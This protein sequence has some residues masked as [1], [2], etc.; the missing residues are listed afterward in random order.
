MLNIEEITSDDEGDDMDVSGVDTSSF[1]VGV[2]K[3]VTKDA[4]VK[5]TLLV[6]GSGWN[7]VRMDRCAFRI[8][9]CRH[10]SIYGG[11][12]IITINVLI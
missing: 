4:G 9:I 11:N 7:T 6:E 12:F 3:N 10:K 8:E 1:V 2:E 5:K